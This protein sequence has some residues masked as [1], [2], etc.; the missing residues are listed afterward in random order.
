LQIQLQLQYDYI[1]F[2]I[3]I[4]SNHDYNIYN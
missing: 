1:T 2:S 4:F 3:T